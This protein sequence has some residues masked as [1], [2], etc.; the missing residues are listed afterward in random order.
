MIILINL[1]EYSKAKKIR[2]TDVDNDTFEGTVVDITDAEERSD[3]EPEEDCIT[4]S[5]HGQHIQF[6]NSDIVL[7]EKID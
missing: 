3:L 7:I 4:I 2:I 5:Y 6:E 1:W